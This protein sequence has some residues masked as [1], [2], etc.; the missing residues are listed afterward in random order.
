[1]WNYLSQLLYDLTNDL[2]HASPDNIHDTIVDGYG[3]TW[4]N[5]LEWAFES[6]ANS[7]YM[8]G[9]LLSVVLLVFLIISLFKWAFTFVFKCFK[10]D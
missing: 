4:Q 1:M 2:F 8:L 10:L 9:Y 3:A 7:F 6:P 5:W